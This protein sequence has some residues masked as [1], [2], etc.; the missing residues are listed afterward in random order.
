MDPV[1]QAILLSW[2]WR[3]EVIIVL[4]LAGTLYSIGWTR[5]RR[6][7]F[8]RAVAEGATWNRNRVRWRLAVR[9]RL[10]SYWFGLLFIGLALL[11]PIE[12][13]SQQLFFMHMIQHLLLVMVAPPLLLI[14][15]PM[16]FL[17][18]GMPVRL[19]LEIGRFLAW[20]LKKDGPLRKGV[21][22]ITQPG[23]LWLIWVTMLIGWHDP[24]LYNAALRIEWVHDVEHLSFFLSSMMLW[25]LITNAGPRVQRQLSLMARI[26]LLLAAVPPN[27]I[28]GVF[29]SFADPLYS[30]YETVPQLWGLSL[31]SDQQIGGVIMWVPGSMMYVFGALILVG[32][33]LSSDTNRYNRGQTAVSVPPPPITGTK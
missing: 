18:W 15:N 27:M 2:D 16:P 3:I 20:L 26:G 13:L 19:R 8:G 25:W 32:R 31:K 10:V 11:S 5:L 23:V 29:L 1:T 33:L 7:T 28:L 22:A 14:A 21:Q 6:R 12:T 17:L 24:G 30:F 9:W 4:A